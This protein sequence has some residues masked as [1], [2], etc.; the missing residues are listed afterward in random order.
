MS[1]SAGLYG[2]MQMLIVATFCFILT[3]E[4]YSADNLQL[5]GFL[6]ENPMVPADSIEKGGPPRDGIPA[7]NS[8]LFVSAEAADFLDDDDRVLGISIGGSAKAYPV[9]I[10]SRHE[11]VN[12]QIR[13]QPVVITYCPLCGSGIAFS[14][15]VEQVSLT[16]GVSG[17]LYN[18]DV[19]LY[20]SETESLWSQISKTAINGPLKGA[21]LAQ[22]PLRHTT[23][24]DWRQRY[25]DTRVLS[26][27]TGFASID[28]DRDPYAGYKNSNRLWF[29]VSNSDMRLGRKDWVLGVTIGGS[30]KAYPFRKM[31]NSTSP[32]QDRI[33]DSSVTIRFDG[34][35]QTAVALDSSGNPL[36]A[37]QLYWFA[38]AAFHPDSSIW[39][40]KDG[41]SRC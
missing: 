1:V 14:A 30:A 9:R 34:E 35:H 17:L 23:W 28:Y 38:W 11:V 26:T 24:E 10:L 16:F 36:E 20:D 32:I 29:A 7:I 8:P 15:A 40:C 25:P 6:I 3:T 4:A 22:L 33:G 2:C 41:A 5:N 27:E 37:V 39:G 13:G 31:K 12:D 19:L 21:E 18:S